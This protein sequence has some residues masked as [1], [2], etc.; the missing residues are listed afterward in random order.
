MFGQIAYRGSGRRLATCR[1]KALPLV[2]VLKDMMLHIETSALVLRVVLYTDEFLNVRVGLHFSFELLVSKGIALLDTNDGYIIA[3]TFFT[4]LDQIIVRLARAN[5][6]ACDLFG[7]DVLINLT[8]NRE[9]L[10][11]RQCLEWRV[12][13]P[14]TEQGLGRHEHQGLAERTN[15]LASKHMENLRCRGGLNHLHVI[16]GTQRSEEHTS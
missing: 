12:G 3:L 6:H 7:F 8:N 1:T 15:H 10:T 4:L 2:H 5:H 9:E 11:R 16:V 14:I 13:R